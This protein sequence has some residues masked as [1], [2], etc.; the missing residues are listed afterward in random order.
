MCLQWLSQSLSQFFCAFI[1]N[2][3][4][5]KKNKT[6]QEMV[7]GKKARNVVFVGREEEGRRR[8]GQMDEYLTFSWNANKKKKIIAL[9]KGY[10]VFQI[11][12]TS[13]TNDNQCKKS[14]LRTLLS[15]GIKLLLLKLC[16]VLTKSDIFLKNRSRGRFL[17]FELPGMFLYTDILFSCQLFLSH[18][19]GMIN[20]LSFTM[21][22]LQV[23]KS[24]FI[25]FK[26]D[27]SG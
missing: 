20:I 1:N 2:E 27:T 6:K 8:E 23:T 22:P 3:Q 19:R 5:K 24:Q 7:V 15:S 17:Q 18:G 25:A 11:P 16:L 14:K 21:F 26:S 12:F 9:Y 13:N 4:S 10:P